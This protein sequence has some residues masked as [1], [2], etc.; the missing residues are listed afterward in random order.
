MQSYPT[1]PNLASMMFALARGWRDKPMLRAWRDGAWHSTTWGEF[2]RMAASCARNLRAAGVA[3]GD[4]VVL[5]MANRPEFP[6]A[7]TALM[8]IR[9]VPVPAYTTNTVDDQAHLLRDSGARAAVVS[10]AA[11]ADRLRAAA[12][13]VHGLDLLVVIDETDDNGGSHWDDLIA[14]QQPQDDIEAEA[15]LIPATALACLIYTSGTGGAPRGVMLPHRCILSNCAGA[16]ELVRPLALKDETY[17]SYLPLSHAYEH[18]VGQFF[19]LS[20]GTEIVYARGAEHLAADMLSV[21]PTIL[22]AVPRVLEVIRMRVLGQVARETPL[23]RRLFQMALTIGLKRLDGA[24]LTVLEHLL[25]PIL[26]RLVRAK[27][28]A[29]FGG[30]LVAAMSG[31][32]RL[33]PEVGRFFLALGLTIMQGYGQT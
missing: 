17:L 18:T 11:L 28:R 29:R 26:N 30:R 13:K 22:T 20:L 1:W 33:E 3:A 27:V 2:G 10:S 19:F 15:A 4:R 32:A 23:R 25:D 12:A 9:A 6:I 31:G 24:K 5:C 21:R 7:E 8:A 14:D 16:F